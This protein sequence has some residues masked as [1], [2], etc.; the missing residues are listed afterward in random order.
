MASREAYGED[1]NGRR[2]CAALCRAHG[3]GEGLVLPPLV[4]HCGGHAGPQWAVEAGSFGGI[5]SG[6][7]EPSAGRCVWL[8]TLGVPLRWLHRC[9]CN[10]VTPAGAALGERAPR[11]GSWLRKWP[12]LC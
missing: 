10:D 12:H 4:A 3:A 9:W 11:V 1:Q 6:H 8:H 7:P 5:L 2:G